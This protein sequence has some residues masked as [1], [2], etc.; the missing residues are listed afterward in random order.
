[1]SGAGLA[2]AVDTGMVASAAGMAAEMEAGTEA[3]A[4]GMVVAEGSTAVL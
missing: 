4:A 1:M 2:V 3:A